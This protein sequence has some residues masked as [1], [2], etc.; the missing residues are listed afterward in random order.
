MANTQDLPT[1]QPEDDSIPIVT[2]PQAYGKSYGNTFLFVAILCVEAI[3]AY[4]IVALN[5]TSIYEWVYGYP[6]GLG[7][8]YEITE[9][10]VNPAGTNGQR[11]LVISIGLQLRNQTDLTELQKKEVIVKDAIISMLSSKTVAELSA[12]DARLQ[13]K[14]E[15]GIMIN[16]ILAGP[17]VRNLFFTQFVMQ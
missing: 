15:L 3:A 7:V 12:V 1:M 8:M 5:Y 4:T 10:T 9:M 6:P 2:I 11:Y 17:A 16:Q 13:M 14:Q